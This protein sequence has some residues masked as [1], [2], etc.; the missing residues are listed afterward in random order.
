MRTV[1]Q[2]LS[3]NFLIVVDDTVEVQATA[4]YPEPIVIISGMLWIMSML[5]FIGGNWQYL[6]YVALLSVACA[7]PPIAL[8]AYTSAQAMPM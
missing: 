1:L 3:G 5:S 7:L 4:K 8:K 2:T 6:K